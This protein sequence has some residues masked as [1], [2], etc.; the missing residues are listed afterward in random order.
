MNDVAPPTKTRKVEPEANLTNRAAEP[1]GVI[2]QNLKMQVYLGIAVLFIVAT[3]VS[4]LHHKAPTNKVDPNTPPSPT[5][6]D[7]SATNIEEIKREIAKRIDSGHTWRS[8]GSGP[9]SQV[10]KVCFFGGSRKICS[11]FCAV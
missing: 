8:R 2:R 5:V 1:H 4:S 9:G 7:A 11:A 10:L 3:A 6:Q